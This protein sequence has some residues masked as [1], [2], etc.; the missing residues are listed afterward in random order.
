MDQVEGLN[1]STE[2]I[3]S[4][5][6]LIK[7]IADQTNLLAL[8]AA[9]EAARA[10]EAGRGF[11]VVADEVRK[12]A[13]RTTKATNDISGLIGNI[14]NDTL[15]AKDCMSDLSGQADDFGQQ[16]IAATEH[17]EEILSLSNKMEAVILSLIHI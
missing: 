4:I 16:G 3:G 14:K 7:E 8:N 9:I 11:A 1:A 10:G 17:I 12:L 15:R 6:A 13:E 2:K 5:L